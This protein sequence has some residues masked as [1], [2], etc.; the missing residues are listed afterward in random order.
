MRVKVDSPVASY[1]FLVRGIAPPKRRIPLPP[2]MINK[3]KR[4]IG[5]SSL[6]PLTLIE[7]NGEEIDFIETDTGRKLPASECSWHP[8]P[9]WEG[10]E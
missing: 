1:G 10:R 6:D 8:V 5:K 9:E 2:S 3:L 4:L 7:S